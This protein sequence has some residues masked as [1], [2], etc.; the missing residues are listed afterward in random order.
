MVDKKPSRKA[1]NAEAKG[2]GAEMAAAIFL[3]LKGYRM[4]VRRAKKTLGEV[5]LIARKGKL[6][7]FIEVKAG[8]GFNEVLGASSPQSPGRIARA[9]AL[10]TSSRPWARSLFMRFDI[11]A[12][13]PGEAPRQYANALPQEPQRL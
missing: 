7:A 12:V 11:V 10:W 13:A 1:K 2:R 4:F 6:L 8:S 9:A 3:M 5:D